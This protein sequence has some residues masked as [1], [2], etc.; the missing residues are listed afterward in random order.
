MILAIIKLSNE[1]KICQHLLHTRR[2]MV[3]VLGLKKGKLQITHLKFGVDWI[4]YPKVLETWFYTLK[5]GSV[6]NSLT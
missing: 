2:E 4:L 5:F 6:S 1:R 3:W